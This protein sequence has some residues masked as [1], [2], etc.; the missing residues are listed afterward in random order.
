M[1]VSISIPGLIYAFGLEHGFCR[2]GLPN[3]KLPHN[4]RNESH[5][6][7]EHTI[8]NQK[9]QRTEQHSPPAR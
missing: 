7:Q 8:M 6:S 4:R 9:D 5:G 2:Q 3:I 1:S